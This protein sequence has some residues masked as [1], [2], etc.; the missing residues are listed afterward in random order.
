M[1]VEHAF[2][3]T[4]ARFCTGPPEDEAV[5]ADHVN[6]APDSGV[7]EITRH[8]NVTVTPKIP[9]RAGLAT[10]A[11]APGALLGRRFA[12]IVRAKS[13][14]RA[15]LLARAKINDGENKS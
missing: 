7:S 1:G 6:L 13:E 11:R 14:W 15:Q 10:R 3:E 4:H 8:K 2:V 12:I 5:I 9:I